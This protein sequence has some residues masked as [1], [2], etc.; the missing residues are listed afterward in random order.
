MEALGQVILDHNPYAFGFRTMQEMLVAEETAAGENFVQPRMYL[1]H[2]NRDD[3]RRYN[4]PVS[5]ADM[6][7]VFTGEEGLPP[8]GLTLR[9]YPTNA[10][11]G[12][13]ELHD[14]NPHRDPMVYPLLFPYGELGN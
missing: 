11:G 4:Q 5:T 10:N 8:A 6:A 12:Y 14:C 2:N 13:R 1:V 3:P 9:V 7:V